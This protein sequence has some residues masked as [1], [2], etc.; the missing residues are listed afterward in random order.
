MTQPQGIS[1]RPDPGAVR[2]AAVASVARAALNVARNV[3]GRSVKPGWPNDDDAQ[4]LTRA[5]STPAS[6][7]NTTA[8]QQVT[9][10]FVESLVPVSAAAAVI[11]RSLQLSFNGA[12]QIGVPA[13]TLPSAAFVGDG[14]PIPVAQGTSAPGA[15][16]TP[17]KIAM[18]VPLTREMIDH[19]D[20][21]RMM[22][23]VLTESI[24]P[25]LDAAMFSAAPSVPGLRPAGV[26]DGVAALAPSSATSPVDAM[27][28]DIQAL[29]EAIA[30]AAGASQP[31]LI[32][33]PA[34]AAALTLRSPRDLWPVV[35]SAGL[36]P[37]S[38]IALVPAAIATVVE[39]PEIEA[40]TDTVQTDDAPGE[41]VDLGGV[42]ARPVRSM[43]QTDSVGLR[44]ILPAT[45]ARRS[46]S[47][48]AWISGANW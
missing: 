21:E 22:R 20:G 1:L 44:F 24:G 18:I 9:L 38:I 29:A 15:V 45:W 17:S 11:A 19:S 37:G 34:Q 32:A 2:T 35:M 25:T 31:L 14:A 10:H 5:A 4:L 30:P 26:L 33:A 27:V 28:A 41:L 3:R 8:L 23:Q 39:A 46:A 40:G 47:A 6:L 42:W 13:L 12:A 16:I 48:V 7:A 43:W 36:A